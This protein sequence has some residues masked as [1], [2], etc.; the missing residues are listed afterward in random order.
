[1]AL[2]HF[3]HEDLAIFC[4]GHNRRGRAGTFGIGDDGGFAT[5]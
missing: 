4:E 3:T 1:L 2:C 5:F